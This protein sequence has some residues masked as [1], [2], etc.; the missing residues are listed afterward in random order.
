MN[1]RAYR[2]R[3]VR[4]LAMAASTVHQSADQITATKSQPSMLGPGQPPDS[5]R[6]KTGS[7]MELKGQSGK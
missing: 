5:A 6:P 1:L 7:P 4:I 3:H 2:Q